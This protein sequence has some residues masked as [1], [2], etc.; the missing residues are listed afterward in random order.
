[1]THEKT[2]LDPSVDSHTDVLAQVKHTLVFII[3][4]LGILDSL[5]EEGLE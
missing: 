4:E 5:E 2:A 1:V 3:I